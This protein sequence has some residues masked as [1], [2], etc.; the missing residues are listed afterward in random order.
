MLTYSSL[1]LE[2]VRVPVSA[3]AAGVA[4]N[5]TGDTVQLAFI[6]PLTNPTSGD[7]KAGSWDT[8]AATGT[9]FAQCL[10]GPSGTI[11]LAAGTYA[12]WVKVTDNPEIPVR[13]CGQ[14]LIT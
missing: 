7:W 11:T 9:Y 10:I 5:P 14:I 3:V 4:V 6:T 12:V 13:M 2:Y 8:E 1:S